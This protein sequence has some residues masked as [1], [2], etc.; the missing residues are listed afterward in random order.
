MDSTIKWTKVFSVPHEK[1]AFRAFVSEHEGKDFY[2]TLLY[3]ER[4]HAF[5]MMNDDRGLL[6]FK[7]MT[8]LGA[9]EG[10]ALTKLKT[11]MEK[12]LPGKFE[13][14]DSA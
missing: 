4:K 10:E 11:W 8:F 1:G 3:F 12:H 13:F 7:H 6:D 9:S 14:R 5:N 2:A